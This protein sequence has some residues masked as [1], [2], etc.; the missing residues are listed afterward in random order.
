MT[1]E[2]ELREKLAT[3]TRIFAMQE[4]LGLFG[5]I[6]V[7]DPKEKRVYMSPAMGF[8][9]ATVTPDDIVVG[10][11]DGKAFDA[12]QRFA[13]E[14]PIHMSLHGTRSDAIAVA[15]VTPAE[16]PSFGIAPAGTCMW[17]PVF[18]KRSAGIPSSAP[19][20]LIQVSAARADSFITSPNEPVRMILPLPGIEVVSMVS[21]SPPTSVQ[22]KPTTCPTWFCCSARP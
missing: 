13:L 22:A 9:K 10:G 14:W 18:S 11:L 1:T 17:S 12:K 8:D 21:S 15:I 20:D 4:M 2:T 3:C 19:C 16:G 5:H 6:S 7:F